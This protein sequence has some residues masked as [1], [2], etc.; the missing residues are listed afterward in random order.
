VGEIVADDVT[1]GF[2]KVERCEP[3]LRFVDDEEDG[4]VMAVEDVTCGVVVEKGVEENGLKEG[5]DGTELVDVE[6]GVDEE[7]TGG[8]MG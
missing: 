1:V 7:G 4:D 8:G 2:A 3:K 5:L 6:E